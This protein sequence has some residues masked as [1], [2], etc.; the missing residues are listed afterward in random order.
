MTTATNSLD[1][2]STSATARPPPPRSNSGYI[3]LG[4]RGTFGK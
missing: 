2:S 3:V 4:Y 1:L